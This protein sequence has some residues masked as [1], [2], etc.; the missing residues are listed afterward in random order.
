VEQKPSITDRNK[1][2]TLTRLTAGALVLLALAGCSDPKS[3][4][5][6]LEGPAGTEDAFTGDTRTRGISATSARLLVKENGYSFYAAMSDS[7]SGG[8]CLVI[9]NVEADEA[10]SACTDS[11]RL[12]PVE[13]ETIGVKAN[14]TADEYDASKELDEGWRQLHQNL[15]VFGL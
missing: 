7:P 14:L 15:L 2:R 4:V 8:V 6:A 13:L 9:Q 5:S 1:M 11:I 10:A 3:R 12:H